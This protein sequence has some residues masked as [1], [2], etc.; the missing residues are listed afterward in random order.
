M[1]SEQVEYR[2][3]LVQF[4]LRDLILRYRQTVMG[5]GWAVLMPVVNTAVFS[6]IVARVTQIETPV[7][8][9]L[10]AYSGF[11]VWNFFASSVRFSM[12]SLT[13]NATL[14][15]K[16]YFPREVL[17]F[18]AVL[19][20]I[21]DLAVGAVVLGV[22]MAFYGYSVTWALLFLPIVAAVAAA[23]TA[24]VALLLAM[25]NLFYRD[26]KYVFEVLVMGWMFATSVAYPVE[27]ADG[28]LRVL[29]AVNPM[30]QIIEAWRS[31]VVYGHLPAAAPFAATACVSAIVMMVGW[32]LFHR[33]EFMFAESI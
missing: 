33:A 6:I 2:E 16:V 22:L 32:H 20:G 21:V 12:S 19:V 3:L 4:A 23:F 31:V 24:G 5:I 8:Y 9:P 7:P 1:L 18:S 29:L 25:G 13:A 26:V 14:I 17:P 30:T 27:S 10:F 15:Q 11:L 28:W